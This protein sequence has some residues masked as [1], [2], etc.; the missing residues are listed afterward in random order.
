MALDIEVAANWR[1]FERRLHL[2]IAQ[3]YLVLE[4]LLFL[5]TASVCGQVELDE[6]G[7]LILLVLLLRL[8]RS[9]L[10]IRDLEGLERLFLQLGT[11]LFLKPDP[12][13]RTFSAQVKFL[14]FGGL[15]SILLGFEELV[16]GHFSGFEFGPEYG[17]KARL[18]GFALA[19]H[20]CLE[21]E[22]LHLRPGLN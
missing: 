9:L 3:L 16:I 10:I 1:S 14:E 8:S 17:G 20:V 4:T 12:L 7:K 11:I 6:S 21:V 19:S 15:G 18:F 5:T 2:C 22:W 13:G